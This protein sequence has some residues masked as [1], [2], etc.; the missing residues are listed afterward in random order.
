LSSLQIIDVLKDWNIWGGVNLAQD[1]VPP[2][3]LPEIS[4]FIP[5]RQI[6]AL[7][8]I[9]RAGKSTLIFQLMEELVNR[10]T[11]EKGLLLKK[12]SKNLRHCVRPRWW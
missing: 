6:L 12:G 7:I 9:R 11:D 3:S 5:D 1:T 10:G 8:G 4:Y 2:L